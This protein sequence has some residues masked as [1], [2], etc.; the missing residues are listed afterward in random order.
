MSPVSKA[1]NKLPAGRASEGHKLSG[2]D[3]ADCGVY[4]DQPE[5][6]NFHKDR[7][8][9]IVFYLQWWIVQVYFF[10]LLLSIIYYNLVLDKTK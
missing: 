4:C 9:T 8:G 6:K 7:I 10:K 3:Q 1:E 2:T 5:G